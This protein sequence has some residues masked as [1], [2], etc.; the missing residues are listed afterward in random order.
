MNYT[1]KPNDSLA[2]IAK[3]FGISLELLL[4]FN[5]KITNPNLI[6]VGQLIHVPN[7]SDVPEVPVPE[8]P[9][10]G[11]ALVARAKTAIGKGIRYQLSQG[12]LDPT[13]PIPTA[14]QKCDCSGFV[15]WILGLSRKTTI[16]F[17]ARYGGWIYTDSMVEDIKSTKGI[18]ERIDTP[19]VGCI[20]VYG[21]GAKIGHVG[22]V[23]EV[24]QG[25]MTKVIHCS[26]G[27]DTKFHD[28]IQETSPSVF[29]RADTVWGRFV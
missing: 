9:T 13:K 25:K 8:P 29:E 28:A 15:C 6:H 1:V 11:S 10:A 12:G 24:K 20:V 14:N 3:K 4:S 5:K 26:K 17:Y 19:E 18:F 23:S 7:V 16:P 22:L 21:A 2:K 27:N